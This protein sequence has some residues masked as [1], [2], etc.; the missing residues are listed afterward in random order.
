MLVVS[1]PNDHILGLALPVTI[2]QFSITPRVSCRE[3]LSL[4]SVTLALSLHVSPGAS[5]CTRWMACN[6]F[7]PDREGPFP[8]TISSLSWLWNIPHNRYCF[9]K[10]LQ[11]LHCIPLLFRIPPVNSFPCFLGDQRDGSPGSTPIPVC[12]PLITISTLKGNLSLFEYET[13]YL[14]LLHFQILYGLLVSCISLCLPPGYSGTLVSL[15][16]SAHSGYIMPILSAF[17]ALFNP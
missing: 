12:T 2:T 17:P 11:L 16:T 13:G 9:P 7:L 6:P 14:T 8:S 15:S 5:A 10:H 4:A 1:T 3:N